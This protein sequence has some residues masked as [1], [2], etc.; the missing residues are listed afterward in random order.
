MSSSDS[1]YYA[2]GKLLITGEYAVL[3]GAKALA[4]PTKL[5]QWL[6]VFPSISTDTIHWISKDVNDL[7][8]FECEINRQFKVIQSTDTQKSERLLDLLKKSIDL[9]PEFEERLF[10]KRIFTRLE[11]DRRW[12]L[13]SSSTLIHLLGQWAKIN[14]FRLLEKTFQGSGY[15]VACAGEKSPIIYQ[16]TNPEASINPVEFN[17]EFKDQFYFIYRGNK[18]F[19]DQEIKKYSSLNIDKKGLAKKVSNL[20]DLALEA[21]TV[22]DFVQIIQDH[23]NLISKTLR[24]PMV[25]DELF[26]GIEGTFKSLGAWGGDFV[27]FVGSEEEVLKIKE[28]GYSTILKWPDLFN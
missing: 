25:K 26:S 28:L 2:H 17:P 19:S 3:D 6:E 5:G 8:W 7:I 13:G 20:T 18:Q 24:Y 11:F 16:N 4:I 23:E 10:G 27:L 1:K 12:G 9:N 14:P 22:N 15:D 21:N